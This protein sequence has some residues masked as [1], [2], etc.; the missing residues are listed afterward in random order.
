M[1]KDEPVRENR[2]EEIAEISRKA[3]E[4]AVRVKGE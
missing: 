2:W 1:V 3:M 4:I